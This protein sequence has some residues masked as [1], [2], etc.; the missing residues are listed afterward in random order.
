M[1]IIQVI[2]VI[3]VLHNVTTAVVRQSPQQQEGP[4]FNS[5]NSSRRTTY[6]VLSVLLWTPAGFLKTRTCSL[7]IAV[8]CERESICLLIPA[9]R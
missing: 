3:Q 1:S 2:Q 8:R 9:L 6:P 7:W 5:Q 4:G